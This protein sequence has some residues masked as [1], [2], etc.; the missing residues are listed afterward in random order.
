MAAIHYCVSLQSAI[1][2]RLLVR[3]KKRAKITKKS[4]IWPLNMTFWPLRWP[5]AVLKMALL[6][7]PSSKS[8]IWIRDRVSSPSRSHFSPGL[9]LT[10]QTQITNPEIATFQSLSKGVYEAEGN[11]LGKSM[12]STESLNMTSHFPFANN[13]FH[14]HKVNWS[15]DFNNITIY[16]KV[17]T[18]HNLHSTNIFDKPI[19]P[20]DSQNM[21]SYTTIIHF[22]C[23]ALADYGIS[24]STQYCFQPTLILP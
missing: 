14:M 23:L 2:H 16:G 22:L 18:S 24:I 11:A 15:R 17:W 7:S 4:P 10:L 6:N 3:Q 5:Q 8:S 9:K 19:W 21:T 12:W 20:L 13:K 1:S